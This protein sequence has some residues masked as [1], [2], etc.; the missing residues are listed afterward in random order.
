MAGFARRTRVRAR[1]ANRTQTKCRWH[2]VPM[3]GQAKDGLP[4][5]QAKQGLRSAAG[6]RRYVE[7][8]GRVQRSESGQIRVRSRESVK[9]SGWRKEQHAPS[10][11]SKPA[12]RRAG[13][14]RITVPPHRQI[15]QDTSNGSPLVTRS[16]SA[17]PR[18]Q[19][20]GSVTQAADRIRQFVQREP[21]ERLTALLHHVTVI[22][23]YRSIRTKECFH[24]VAE[25][26]GS[27]KFNRLAGVH[28]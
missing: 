9:F 8:P 16:A 27:R 19:D 4:G 11:S 26:D 20:R 24:Y 13:G 3:S 15:G 21:R 6:T 25:V 1:R 2:F 12:N 22:V 14:H 28:A 10:F 18:P 7:H 17:G 5:L 23:Y